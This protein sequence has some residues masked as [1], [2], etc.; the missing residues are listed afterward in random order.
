MRRL[1]EALG[2][3]F[4]WLV[5]GQGTPRTDHVAKLEGLVEKQAKELD[6]LRDRVLAV[7][8]RLARLDGE[9]CG[10]EPGVVQA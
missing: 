5:Y 10:D 8:A 9:D 4:D 7:E 6:A 1:A 2:E 3:D